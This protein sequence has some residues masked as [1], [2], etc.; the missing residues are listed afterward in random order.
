MIGTLLGGLKAARQM[1]RYRQML[2]DEERHLRQRRDRIAG[3]DPTQR[4]DA[5]Y[6][7]N[8]LDERMQQRT[9][10]TA[11]KAEIAG[12]PPDAAAAANAAATEA[13]AQAVGSIAAR[14]VARA[15][16]ADDQYEARRA[17]LMQERRQLL[18]MQ[19]R[20]SAD[21]GAAFDSALIAGLLL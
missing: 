4:A 10:R 1:S 12:A 20:D 17:Q 9:R 18:A 19:A 5:R 11:A 2:S 21:A 16:Q 13:M 6:Q 3:T 8:Q 14:G 15:D 7:L